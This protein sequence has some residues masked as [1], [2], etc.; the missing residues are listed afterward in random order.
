[1]AQRGK[2]ACVILDGG[3]RDRTARA[4]DLHYLHARIRLA[5]HHRVRPVAHVMDCDAVS[6]VQL[7]K[8]TG[9]V[10]YDG[11]VAGL[12]RARDVCD[13]HTVITCHE[14]VRSVGYF[15]HGDVPRPRQGDYFCH[16]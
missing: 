3:H 6:P 15:V 13:M 14:S 8:A 4:G 11:H 5:G 12:V 9:I 16:V 2:S 7:G 1:M 10:G